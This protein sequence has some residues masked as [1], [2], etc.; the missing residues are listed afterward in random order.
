VTFRGLHW[1]AV[2]GGAMTMR[3]WFILINAMIKYLSL[4]IEKFFW[5]NCKTRNKYL[6]YVYGARE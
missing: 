1:L 5:R 6:L 4:S 3:G 2:G